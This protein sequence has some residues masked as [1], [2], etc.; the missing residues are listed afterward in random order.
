MPCTRVINSHMRAHQI[1]SEEINLTPYS[2]AVDQALEHSLKSLFQWMIETLSGHRKSTN[3][4]TIEEIDELFSEKV[5]TGHLDRMIS[6]E[7]H[8]IG[9]QVL[10]DRF[11]NR[12]PR[13]INDD[14]QALEQHQAVLRQIIDDYAANKDYDRINFGFLKT[15]GKCRGDRIWINIEFLQDAA[16]GISRVIESLKTTPSNRSF[17]SQV[18]AQVKKL[19]RY[20]ASFWIQS[21]E[22]NEVFIHEMVHMI[23]HVEQ[24]AVNRRD[25]EYRSYTEK[26]PR[27]FNLAVKNLSSP[28]DFNIYHSSPQEISAQAHDIAGVV[29]SKIGNADVT[30][31]QVWSGIQMAIGNGIPSPTTPIETKVYRRYAKLVYQ[32]VM[33]MLQQRRQQLSQPS[34][35]PA[36]GGKTTRLH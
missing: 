15:G 4:Q 17:I 10:V 23:Q 33:S 1:I 22:I 14:P 8:K 11:V 18:I 31:S 19:S 32:L 36:T 27:R 30:A 21:A 29:A 34:K 20:P 3:Y 9:H 35:K 26:D 5:L 2:P 13:K 16:R 24:W 12:A 6:E 28:Q 25:T 7:F